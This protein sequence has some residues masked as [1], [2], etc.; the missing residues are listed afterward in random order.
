MQTNGLRNFAMHRNDTAH[1]VATLQPQVM[2]AA[3]ATGDAGLATLDPESAARRYLSTA[4]ESDQLPSFTAASVDGQKCQ[5]KSLGT[6]MQPLTRT[7]TVKFR[8]YYYRIPVY[9]SIVTVELDDKNQLVAINSAIGEPVNVDPVAKISPAEALEIMRARLPGG[10]AMPEPVPR[11]E[12]YFDGAVKRWRLVYVTEDVTTRGSREGGPPTFIDCVVDAHT[13]EM[14]AQLPRIHSIAMEP[15]METGTG[16]EPGV[17]TYEEPIQRRR[18]PLRP[19]LAEATGPDLLG[20]ERHISYAIDAQERKRLIDLGR[21]VFTYDFQYRNVGLL[22]RL[23]P[24][25]AILNPPDPWDPAAI[26]AHA[27]ATVVA[28]YLREVF[29]REGLD[30]RGGPIIS[31]INCVYG[32][33]TQ[34]WMNAAWIGTQI[35][36]GQR[37]V[38]GKLRSYAIS[39]DVVAHEITHGLTDRTAR[40]EYAGMS[41][42]LNESY[43]DIFGILISND[44]RPDIGTW[45]WE[46]GE[47]L[48]GT[49]LPL[50]DIR[51][52]AKHDQPEHMDQ[53]R[54]LPNDD[55]NDNGGVHINSG[56]HNRAA[57]NLISAQ[58]ED[59]RYLFEPRTAAILFYIA[60]TQHL[61]RTSGFSDSRRG[62]TLAAQSYLRDDPERAAKLEA[63]GN[64]FEAAGIEG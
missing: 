9:G 55:F 22:G 49:G 13:G 1:L 36:Y 37:L 38:D 63:I 30:N 29:K 56:I 32:A 7:R 52:P 61:S 47:D 58:G 45:N 57:Y 26:S 34:E 39:L 33:G 53:Y 41:G 21:R 54:E 15:G 25:G 50:R 42:A 6:E 18:I 24:G 40:L 44:E 51:Q 62:V 2:S 20:R 11:L 4:L 14:V 43:S 5:F 10:L 27:N 31:T 23:L 12:F 19:G 3:R 17:E 35:V 64:A 60:L 59:G 48:D 16:T 28:N 8:Q 46:L